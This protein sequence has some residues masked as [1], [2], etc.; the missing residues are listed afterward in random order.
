[1]LPGLFG[2]FSE[3]LRVSL[4]PMAKDLVRF[5]VLNET[6]AINASRFEG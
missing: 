2:D 6:G 1:M 4:I 3:S 5:G